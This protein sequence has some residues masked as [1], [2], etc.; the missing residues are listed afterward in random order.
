MIQERRSA[1]R[2]LVS[3][4]ELI[5]IYPTSRFDHSR[6]APGVVRL[7]SAVNTRGHGPWCQLPSRNSVSPFLDVRFGGQ[8][9]V[10]SEGVVGRDDCASAAS[11]R[12]LCWYSGDSA[13][14]RDSAVGS[15][16][17]LISY[18]SSFI[19]ASCRCEVDG[20]GYRPDDQADP[21]SDN[22]A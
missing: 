18:P 7:R 9:H 12:H 3:T 19:R 8:S 16:R 11:I 21:A 15:F 13:R 5:S 20:T 6:W 1:A 4:D 14:I 22:Y 2:L 10:S 17:T